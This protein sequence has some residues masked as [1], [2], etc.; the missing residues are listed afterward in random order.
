MIRAYYYKTLCIR[1]LRM[2]PDNP[3]QPSLMF[4]SKVKAYSSAPLWGFILT[5]PTNIRLD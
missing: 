4:A 3:F 5:L 1:N 2:F